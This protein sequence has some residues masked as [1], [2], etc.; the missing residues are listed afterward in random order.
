MARSPCF[1]AL[2]RLRLCRHNAALMAELFHFR[3]GLL[4][5]GVA[6]PGL[7]APTSIG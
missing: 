2:Y 1:G 3:C 5:Q 6:S 7:A 4:Q